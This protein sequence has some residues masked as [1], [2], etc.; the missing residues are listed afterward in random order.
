MLGSAYGQCGGAQSVPTHSQPKS[1][2]QDAAHISF[3]ANFRWGMHA[4]T[5]M[6]V[7]TP[8]DRLK[9]MVVLGAAICTMYTK[10]GKA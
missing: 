7:P 5:A 8:I 1:E 2:P 9:P 10:S 4:H 3:I 6:Q